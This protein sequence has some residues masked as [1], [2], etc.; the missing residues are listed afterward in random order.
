M[1]SLRTYINTPSRILGT[2]VHHV[3]DALSGPVEWPLGRKSRPWLSV[4]PA[5]LWRFAH[6]AC[7]AAGLIW[8]LM[9][10]FHL[11]PRDRRVSS[12]TSLWT[13]WGG[14]LMCFP[15]FEVC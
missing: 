5:T 8:M 6:A 4:L 12:R 14:I 7:S 9:S 13:S 15:R 1:A 10:C 3:R 11:L 2:S